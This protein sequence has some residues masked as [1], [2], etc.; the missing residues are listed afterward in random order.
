[1]KMLSRWTSVP[2]IGVGGHLVQKLLSR[3]YCPDTETQTHSTPIVLPGLITSFPKR[4]LGRVRHYSM[5]CASC[6]MRNV[7]W[8]RYETLRKHYGTL[9]SATE[10]CRTLWSVTEE[11]T[12]RY[13]AVTER[14]GSVMEPLTKISILPILN[15]PIPRPTSLTTQRAFGSLSHFAAI[16]FR[17]FRTDRPPADGLGK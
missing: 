9:R 12:E 14:Y 3:S 7:I 13:R 4:N 1:M 6:I 16:H 8:D 17:I 2:H 5:S 11:F 15:T 10:R